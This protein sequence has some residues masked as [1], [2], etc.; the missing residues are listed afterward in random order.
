MLRRPIQIPDTRGW[1]TIG[2]FVLV[3]YI[4]HLMHVD[5]KLAATD[6]FK[7]VA[8]LICGSGGLGL[9]FSFVW[10]GTKSSAGAVEALTEMGR[11]NA[12]TT[13]GQPT[14]NVPSATSVNIDQTTGGNGGATNQPAN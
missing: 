11:T 8:T 10:G 7:T 14:V 9:L 6:L 4:F 3:F 1:T 5:P 12:A 2:L 13:A